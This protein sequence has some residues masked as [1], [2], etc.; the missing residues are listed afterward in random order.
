[1]KMDLMNF[2]ALAGGLLLGALVVLSWGGV[3]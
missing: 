2:V 3:L 1:M